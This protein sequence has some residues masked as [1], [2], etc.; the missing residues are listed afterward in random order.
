MLWSPARV[1]DTDGI[2]NVVLKHRSDPQTNLTTLTM[3]DDGTL[4]SVDQVTFGPGTADTSGGRYPDGQSIRTTN[5]YQA[6]PAA[7]TMARK[8]RI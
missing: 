7:S 8:P 2:T 3:K 4:A 1:R 6:A 5:L